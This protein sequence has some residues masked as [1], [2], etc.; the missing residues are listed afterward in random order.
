MKKSIL[1]I[2]FTLFGVYGI[3]LAQVPVAYF[4]F[5]GSANDISGNGN[6]GTV[7]GAILSEDRFNNI[8]STYYFDGVDD[9]I[10]FTL[11]PNPEHLTMSCW[12]NVVDSSLNEPILS[13]NAAGGFSVNNGHV[14]LGLEL[15][16]GDYSNQTQVAI[17]SGQWYHVGITYN[18][19][20][21]N[22]FVNGI[23]VY[24][25]YDTD[26]INYDGLGF[27]V[28]CNFSQNN[29]FNGLIDDIRIY[30]YAVDSAEMVNQYF[31]GLY[32]DTITTEVFDTT[33]VNVYDTTYINVY[34]TTYINIYDTTYVNV[35][36]T[37][38][39]TVYDSISVTD[40]LIIDVEITGIDPPD[41][42]NTIKIFPN[43]AHDYVI[44]NTGDYIQIADYTIE[45][46]NILSQT[47]FEASLS[48]QEFQIDVNTFGDLGTYFIRIFDHLGT[49]KE[50]RTLILE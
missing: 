32:W 46:V 27:F 8:N 1:L 4:P 35:Y 30:D 40:T 11:N 19:S 14:S 47:V 21:V 34:D 33:Y 23:Q 12:F 29:F 13:T 42:I 26:A 43:P 20:Q 15:G 3:I 5:C 44:V 45:I 22:Y 49:L 50:V 7:T 39:I 36:D 18:G 38:Y 31:S 17:N 6:H 48:Q 9:R 28:G 37:T 41:N 25:S 2:L 16:S 24:T 10:N